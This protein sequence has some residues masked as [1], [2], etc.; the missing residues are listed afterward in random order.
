MTFFRKYLVPGFVFQSITIGGGYGTGREL[1]QYFL[2]LGPVKGLA[3]MLVATLIWSVILALSFE[4]ARMTRTFDYRTFINQLLGKG[5]LL[6][7]VVYIC[8]L[9]LVLAVLGG[10][11]GLLLSSFGLQL[12]FHVEMYQ[13]DYDGD[14]KVVKQ[15]F[16]LDVPLMLMALVLR[17]A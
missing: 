8:G 17:R 11:L 5:W 13:M 15:F 14:P 4:L 2:N 12:M 7:E 6:Y 10:A 3:A 1:V 16:T 9:V